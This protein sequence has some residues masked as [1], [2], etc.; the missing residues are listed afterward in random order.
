MLLRALLSA[1]LV[2]A[3]AAAAAAAAAEDGPPPGPV[4]PAPP[5]VSPTPPEPATATRTMPEYTPS[6]IKDD[7]KRLREHKQAVKDAKEKPEQE[8]KAAKDALETLRSAVVLK[9]GDRE[10]PAPEAHYW[11]NILH[12][13]GKPAEAVVQCRRWLEVAPEDNVNFVGTTTLLITS[14]AASGDYEGARAAL[15]AAADTTYRDK[16]QARADVLTTIAMLMLRKGELETALETLEACMTIH[17]GDVECAIL[18]VE[19]AQRLGRP[20]EAVRI[21]HKAVEFFREGP[22]AVRARALLEAAILVG[23]PAPGFAGAKW[24]KG[25][26]G[27]VKDAD[28]SGRVTVV[29]SWNMKSAWNRPFFERLN[30]FLAATRDRGVGLVG[31]SRL[32]RFDP[33]VMETQE[34]LTDEQELV[35]YDMWKQQYGVT[36]PLAVYPYRD[37]RMLADWA[38]HV[39]PLWIVIGK[40]GKIAAVSA[41]KDDERIAVMRE[42]VERELAR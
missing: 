23:R 8:Q 21:A 12:E 22:T 38:A 6:G 27:P 30:A 39:V 31:I 37:Q 2:G 35:F 16:A 19:T 33:T 29:I 20:A 10:V 18:A 28:L 11:A 40:D 34:D 26:G 14:L 24:W 7:F 25:A 32:A 4:P 41:G 9:W 1:A 36:W 42:F 5:P 3:A 17:E 13:A 15:E